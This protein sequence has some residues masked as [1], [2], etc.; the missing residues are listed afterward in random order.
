MLYIPKIGDYV[1]ILTYDEVK[2][3]VV[4]NFGKYFKSSKENLC[5]KLSEAQNLRK[6]FE[7][8][9]IFLTTP[10]EVEKDAEMMQSSSSD[11]CIYHCNVKVLYL[12]DPELQ[13][14][15]T[16]PIIKDRL[17]EMLSDFKKFK[18]RAI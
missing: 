12:L 15:N 5:S 13:L 11:N 4:I 6:V 1:K 18:V 10:A 7:L 3:F 2:D 14:I 9:Y 8:L 17:K 16:K